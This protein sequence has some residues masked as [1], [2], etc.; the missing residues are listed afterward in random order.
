[1]GVGVAH[2]PDPSSQLDAVR[3]GIGTVLRLNL[4]DLLREPLPEEMAKLLRQL[5]Q[6][7]EDNH[8]DC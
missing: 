7:P 1:M 4:A 6:P 3:T 8:G 2:R 5:G